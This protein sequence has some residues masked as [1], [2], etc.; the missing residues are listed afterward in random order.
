MNTFDTL[1]LSNLNSFF[2]N[3]VYLDIETSGL[4]SSLKDTDKSK[5]AE[6]IEIGAIKFKNGTITIF[7]SLIKPEKI[8]PEAIFDLCQGL[9]K[10]DLSKAPLK[11][12]ILPKLNEFLEGLP[13]I[14]HNGKFERIFLTTYYKEIGLRFNNDILDT[15]ELFAL[16]EPHHKEFNLNYLIKEKLSESTLKLVSEKH[17]GLIDAKDTLLVL[18][19]VLEN[20]N[21]GDF[22]SGYGVNLDGWNWLPLI[23]HYVTYVE[24]ERKLKG[25]F[26]Q[27]NIT[28]HISE[29][30]CETLKLIKNCEETLKDIDAWRKLSPNY[31]FRNAQYNVT[32]NVRKSLEQKAFTIMEAPTG[33]GKSIGY[34]LPSIYSA[35]NGERVFISTNTKELQNQLVTKDIPKLLKAFNLKGKLNYK[36]IK[37]KSNYLC[38]D[39]I[40]DMLNSSFNYPLKDRLG[41][42]YLHRYAYGGKFGDSEEINYWIID[43]FNLKSLIPH[44]N[45][46]NDNCD[47]NSCSR[48]CFYK[49]TIESLEESNLIILNHALLLRWPYKEEVK[50]VV[51]D[52]AHNLMDLLFDVYAERVNALELSK[53]LDE[54]LSYDGQKGCLA[55]LWKHL[56]NKENNSLENIKKSIWEIK[57]TIDTISKCASKNM[58]LQYNLD[59]SFNEDFSNY[60]EVLSA[61]KILIEDLYSL[62]KPIKKLIDYNNLED[63]NSK[64]KNKNGAILVKKCDKLKSCIDLISSF[65]QGED[66]F[67]CHGFTCTK[68]GLIWEAYIKDLNPATYFSE[69]FLKTLDSGIFLSA[70]LK[71]SGNYEA[72]KNALGINSLENK[73]VIEV[74]DIENSFNLEKRTV[75]CGC[76]DGI[77]YNDTAFIPYVKNSVLKLIDTIPGNLLILFTSKK[78]QDLFKEAILSELNERHI[79]LYEN[80]KDVVHLKDKT[81]KSILIG[82]KG[83]FEGIDVAGDGLNCVVLEK[84][85]N[86]SPED[87]LFKKLISK[88]NTHYG[89]SNINTPRVITAFKQCF[90]RLVRTEYDFGYFIILDGGTN[91]T[92]W[93][94]IRNEYPKVPVLRKPINVVIESMNKNYEKWACMNLEKIICETRFQ[95]KQYLKLVNFMDYKILQATLNEFYSIEFEK[96]NLTNSIELF[97]QNKSLKGKYKINGYEVKLSNIGVIT[98]I[99]SEL[100]QEKR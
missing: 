70:T 9:T 12:E 42:V 62:F 51:L 90:G 8:V 17:R 80:K 96:R 33:T 92:L 38:F 15:M 66:T 21:I 60:N 91:S 83:F 67:K 7:H 47:I 22:L 54:I 99:L 14:C 41:L 36:V 58:H 74:T 32:K 28:R 50:N 40:D 76:S 93:K 30:T 10:E 56:K 77:N 59:V 1:D 11:E 71:S 35:L 24:T 94:K 43:N 87:P 4:D 81:K 100:A 46:G 39:E 86:I 75:I 72:F 37:G 26:L 79:R 98:K 95:L 44:C 23:S 78:R 6:I 19:K 34:L 82:S 57:N 18:N 52:E 25:L 2:D 61:F 45:A 49:E 84:L 13:L 27:P 31:T 16:L 55:R 53:L 88:L 85:P 68:E 65:I 64:N 3:V 73:Q 5:W 69:R 48:L 20:N 89:Y 29:N 97:I 63:E